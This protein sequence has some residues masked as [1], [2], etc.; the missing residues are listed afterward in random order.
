MISFDIPKDVIGVL[1]RLEKAGYETYLAGGCVRDMLL[2]GTPSDFDM[3]T[4]A[5]PQTVSTLFEDCRVIPTGI[6][7]GTVTVVYQGRCIEIT[8]FRKDGAYT[9]HRHPDGVVFSS[10]AKDDAARRDFTINA[11]FYSPTRGVLDFYQGAKDL[12]SGII[13]C[14]GEAEKRFEED[15]LRILRALRFAARLRFSI[16]EETAK[17]MLKTACMLKNI[18]AERILSELK[19]FFAADGCAKLCV[20]YLDIF[21]PLLGEAL[22]CAEEFSILE[23]QQATFRLAAFF[24]LYGGKNGALPLI[25]GLKPDK[26]TASLVCAATDA[27]YS[28]ALSSAEDIAFTVSKYGAF[29]FCCMLDFARSMGHKVYSKA[30]ALLALLQSKSLPRSVSE[31]RVGGNELIALGIKAGNDIGRV[32]NHLF[33]Q[34]YKGLPNEKALLVQAATDYYFN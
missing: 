28:N 9:D 17:A 29:V 27:V 22:P 30:D 5:A 32:L 21:K 15:A 11:M 2:G 3:A 23:R 10:S 16:E 13:R 12:E 18:A 4:A 25:K 6:K 31:L 19:G 1:N 20:E 14:V 7:H 33:V 8:T 34:C 26:E 24:A